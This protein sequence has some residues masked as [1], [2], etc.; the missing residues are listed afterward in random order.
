MSALSIAPHSAIPAAIDAVFFDLD[1]TLVSSPLDFA[2]IR[3]ELGYAQP[4]DFLQ[5]LKTAPADEAARIRAIIERHEDDDANRCSA[6]PG[7]QALLDFCQQQGWPTVVVTRNSRPFA[8]RKLERAGLQLDRLIARDDGP[9]KPDPTVFYQLFDHYQL[10]PECVI[11]LGDYTYDIQT[12]RNAGMLSALIY[13]GER[14]SY[15]E[16]ADICLTE[17]ADLQAWLAQ[18]QLATA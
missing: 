1:G 8:E 13:Q 10:R 6:M 2:A 3:A 15:A 7:A 14:P 4:V 5:L 16:Q 17:L 9:A 12:A 11:Y 18:Q